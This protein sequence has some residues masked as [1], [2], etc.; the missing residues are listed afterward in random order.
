MFAMSFC[1]K[2]LSSTWKGFYLINKRLQV[3]LLFTIRTCIVDHRFETDFFLN[4]V[5]L[6]VRNLVT[7]VKIF[8]NDNNYLRKICNA[9]FGSKITLRQSTTRPRD[10]G[11]H[12]RSRPR[13]AQ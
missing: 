11:R 9:R 10:L 1:N 8:L 6:F 5:S 12:H 2:C 4:L 7:T 3:V 13:Y